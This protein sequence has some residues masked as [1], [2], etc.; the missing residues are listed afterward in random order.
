MLNDVLKIIKLTMSKYTKEIYCLAW[1]I[2]SDYALNV[3]QVIECFPCHFWASDLIHFYDFCVIRYLA[4]LI[5]ENTLLGF[6]EALKN[7]EH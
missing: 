3:D 1:K 5:F 7:K 2:F 6:H 4:S